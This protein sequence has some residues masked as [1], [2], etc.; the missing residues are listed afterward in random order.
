MKK[1]RLALG[2]TMASGTALA[3]PAAAANAATTT[4]KSVGTQPDRA[5][6]ISTPFHM[7]LLCPSGYW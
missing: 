5:L 2:A 3:M 1:V 7:R 6:A 4:N